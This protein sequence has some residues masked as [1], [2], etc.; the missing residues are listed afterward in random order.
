MLTNLLH[1]LKDLV[2]LLRERT[3]DALMAEILGI[4]L[5]NTAPVSCCCVMGGGAGLASSAD[6]ASLA[7]CGS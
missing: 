5:W 4:K 7:M 3:H 2:S 1:T 6:P